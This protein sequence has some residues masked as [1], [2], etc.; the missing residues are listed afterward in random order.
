MRNAERQLFERQLRQLSEAQSA[1]GFG[2]WEWNIVDDT[3]DCSDQLAR[4]FGVSHERMREFGMIQDLV[5]PDD[6]EGRLATLRDA[7]SKCTP[8]N[9]EFRIVR[10]DGAVRLMESC[11]D[12]VLGADGTA[13]RMLGTAQ[14]I[15]ERRKTEI[16]RQNLSTMLDASDD[17]ITACSREGVF[18]SWN[19]G[20]EKLYG[21]PAQEALGRGLD[22]IVPAEERGSNDAVW[23][24]I[25]HGE[26][27][28]PVQ[29]MPLT[30]DGRKVVVELTFSPVIDATGEVI[31]VA[32]IGRDITAHKQAQAALAE[33]HAQAVEASELMSQFMANMSHELRT[34]L[35]GVIGVS[36]LLL[37]TVLSDEQREYVEALGISGDAL[38]S[39]IEDILD[40]SKTE[41]GKLE[42][43]NEPFDLPALVEDVCSVVAI[44]RPDRI[45]EVMACV[46]TNVPQRVYGDAKR[47]RQVLTNLTNNAAKFTEAGEVAVHVS[48]VAVAPDRVRLRFEIID[49][50]IGIEP[51]AQQTIFESFMQADGSTTRR[52]G[53]TG[54]GLTIA[55]QLVD[56]MGGEIGVTS[57]LGQGSTFWF[58]LPAQTTDA[59]RSHPVHPALEGVRVLI[60]DDKATGRESLEHQLESWGMTVATAPD[61]EQALAAL[62]AAPHMGVPFDLALIDFRMPAMNGGQLARAI[63]ADLGLRSTAIVMMVAARDA[64]DAMALADIA[65]LVPKPVRRALLR[66]ELARIL[67]TQQPTT[68][69]P[70]TPRHPAPPAAGRGVLLAEDNPVNQLVAVRLLEQRGYTVDVAANGR[71]ALELHEHAQYDVI[72]MD[73]QMPEL[74]GYQT[75]TEIR[76][77]EGDNRHT[78]VIAMT[79]STMPGDVDR[80]LA[81]GM[82]YH[83]GKPIRPAALDD[84]L[85]HV[86]DHR[87]P[88]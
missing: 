39:V 13:V 53:G 26:R 31:A 33:A 74:D 46:Q 30:K 48:A 80:C 36:N 42:L 19:R 65:G 2:I 7:Q 23:E 57:A 79:A 10:P 49:T 14:D 47:V 24:R 75:T 73:C 69:A 22:L 17:A 32:T 85:A 84:I 81:A 12:V 83:T 76:R 34:P 21:Y 40:F 41:A 5:H 27:V 68:A 52:Y 37:G 1:A 86:L 29:S 60:V 43:V 35:N 87:T 64:R 59:D 56:L 9:H 4:I 45:V 51:A 16:E 67:A 63:K 6:R 88:A 3:V 58:T 72:F 25:F 61:G 8:F 82:D 15:T 11:G 77:R 38:M 50:G 78:P 18:V 70:E 44:G 20:A 54:L 28:D 62:R 55:K 71:E 66:D